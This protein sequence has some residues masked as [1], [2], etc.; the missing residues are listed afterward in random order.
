MGH[1][2]L[3][4]TRL[5]VLLGMITAFLIMFPVIVHSAP[6]DWVLRTMVSELERN[7]KALKIDEYD[8]AYFISYS[9]RDSDRRY[10]SGKAGAIFQ[11]NRFRKRFARVDVRVGDYSMDSSEDS[12]AFF[13]P[14]RKFIPNNLA[15]I[16]KSPE[17]LSRVL[18]LLTDHGYKAAL[19]SYLK[20]KGK[21]VHD[22]K[23]RATDSMTRETALR[24]VE[25]SDAFE[26]DKEIWE[27]GVR[28]I[29]AAL[30][31]FSD[32]FDSSVEVSATR[33]T[34]YFTSTEGTRVKTV[35]DYYMVFVNA[36]TRAKDG[37]LM[38]DS[39]TFYSRKNA[40]MPSTDEV[41]KATREMASRLVELRS[42]PV[43]NPATVPVLMSPQAT[44]VFFHETIGHRLEGQRQEDE[45]EGR[46]F[47]DHVGRS[48][49]PEFIDIYDDPT[50]ARW[51]DVPLNGTYRVDDEG[52]A[53]Q[54]V[55][56]VKDGVLKGFL[57]SRKPVQGFKRSNGHGR[58]DGFQRPVGRMANFIVKG[59]KPVSSRR[60][61]EMLLEEVRKRGKPFG[62]IIDTIAGGST[63][64]S[65]YG[66]QAFK[67]IPRVVYKIDA[68]TGVKER[69]RGIEIVGTPLSSIGRIVSTSDK[70]GVFNGYCGAE[71]G[72]I[73]VSTVAP[74]MLF[75][76]IELQRSQEAPERDPVLP[77][78]TTGRVEGH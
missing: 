66:Y 62:L 32:I 52:V 42:A 12:E 51:E 57:M 43:L 19:V 11:T 54:R 25:T 29:S 26:F 6:V 67:G 23:T 2:R 72:S 3:L 45:E 22:P 64:T 53:S 28:K 49:L 37:R 69:V 15:P 4:K 56:L 63:N 10:V 8:P 1:G 36:V 74:E 76:E 5:T 27:Q 68:T 48:I 14:G 41:E 31:D 33:L 24:F 16:D 21:R 47:K 77:P 78:P 61:K 39:V 30:L 59:S 50:T 38:E 71:S 73:P 34:R 13:G 40:D 55:D 44:G 17:A 60:L 46:T 35:D 9:V 7:R 18:W 65:T 58:S 20:V 70:Y 75:A